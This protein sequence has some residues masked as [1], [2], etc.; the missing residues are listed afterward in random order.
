MKQTGSN[1]YYDVERLCNEAV[2]RNFRGDPNSVGNVIS[3][4]TYDLVWHSFVKWCFTQ[5]E[6]GRAVNMPQFGTIGYQQ[7][8][9]NIRILYVRLS[10][11]FLGN[12]QLDYKPEMAEFESEAQNIFLEPLTKPNY[13]AMA[14]SANLD[15]TVFTTVITNI[16]HVLGELLYENAVVELDL[17]EMG[18]FFANNRQILY[19]PLN[20][21][22]SH[23]PQGKQTVKALMDYGVSGQQ[24]NNYYT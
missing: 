18:K 4:A 14:K 20:K 15:K 13:A 8:K 23:A 22:K 19:D 2:E 17:Q 24:Q 16:F 10:E 21:L 3:Q 11:N 7:I 6:A 1:S 12:F 5:A 9:D